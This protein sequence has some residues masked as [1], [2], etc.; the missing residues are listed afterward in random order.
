MAD[1][2]SAAASLPTGSALRV[3]IGRVMGSLPPGLASGVT[4]GVRAGAVARRREER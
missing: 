2:P 3:P 4:G 1:K